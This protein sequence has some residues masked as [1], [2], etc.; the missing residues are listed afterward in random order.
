MLDYQWDGPEDSDE[1]IESMKQYKLD[2]EKEQDI[3]FS[4]RGIIEYIESKAQSE[5]IV[6]DSKWVRN[7]DNPNMQCF[8]KS[9]ELFPFVRCEMSYIKGYKM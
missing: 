6:C 3:K 7:I 9:D 5:S 2:H 8:V 1:E 4:K